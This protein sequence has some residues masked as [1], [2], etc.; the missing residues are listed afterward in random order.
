MNIK[1][2]SA[3]SKS[4]KPLP[5]GVTPEELAQW[6][7]QYSEVY[8]FEVKDKDRKDE[9]VG[10]WMRLPSFEVVKLVQD[11]AKSCRRCRSHRTALRQLQAA[12]LRRY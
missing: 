5:L 8:F 7:H 2:I 3:D 10:A 1:V 11:T 9:V 4:K 12:C 6:K